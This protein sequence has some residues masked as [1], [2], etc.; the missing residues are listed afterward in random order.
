MVN[1]VKENS[2]NLILRISSIPTIS[3]PGQGKAALVL[4]NSNL[5]NTLLFTP[6][7]SKNINKKIINNEILNLR[8]FPFNNNPLPLKTNF[9]MRKV[10]SSLRIIRVLFS[11]AYILSKREIYSCKLVHIHHLFYSIPALVLKLLGAK[12]I[13]TIHGSDINKIEK[14]FIFKNILRLFDKILCVSNSQYI[15][16]K[17]FLSNK[18]IINIGNGVDFQFYKSSKYYLKRQKIILAVGNLRWQKNHKLLIKSFAKIYKNNKS[19]KLIILGEGPE[20][21][22]LETLISYYDLTKAVNLPGSISVEETKNLMNN[23]M[24]FVMCSTTEALPKALLEACASGC[25]CIA[26]DVGD[27]SF[28]LEGIGITCRNNN[29]EE[30][31]NKLNFLINSPQ[32]CIKYSNLAT[33]K[34]ESFSWLNYI[35]KHLQIYKHLTYKTE[36]IVFN[37]SQENINI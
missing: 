7:N 30:L 29:E 24:I 34:M 28:I 18:K 14:S 15:V 23:A 31:K 11:S 20:R 3:N 33:K 17:S 32:A 35:N 25:A 37:K 22:N 27:C 36:N 4:S 21:K 13:I 9:I 26:T 1:K 5:F 2:E 19:W 16:L 10:L 8:F 6:S 12:I